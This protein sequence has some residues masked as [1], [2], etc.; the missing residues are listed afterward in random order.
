MPI[1]TALAV[2]VLVFGIL[3]AVTAAGAGDPYGGFGPS[4]SSETQEIGPNPNSGA[5]LPE[6]DHTLPWL[7]QQSQPQQDIY[8]NGGAQPG[9]ADEGY[10]MDDEG[11]H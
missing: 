7:Q 4:A 5:A 3:G 1:R 6:I 8:G 2:C 11:G 10:D 9:S